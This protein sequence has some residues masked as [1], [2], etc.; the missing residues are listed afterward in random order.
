MSYSQEIMK[1]DVHVYYI[2]DRQ[3][4]IFIQYMLIDERNLQQKKS[5]FSLIFQP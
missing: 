2:T 3:T 5:D 1:Q 4:Q